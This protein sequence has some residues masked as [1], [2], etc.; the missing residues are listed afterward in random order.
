MVKWYEVR[1]FLAIDRW[2]KFDIVL[3]FPKT[4]RHPFSLEKARGQTHFYSFQKGTWTF[5][6]M[7]L[8]YVISRIL[9]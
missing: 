6:F 9:K 5:Y 8:R 4:K 3:P 2:M 7:L 1:T